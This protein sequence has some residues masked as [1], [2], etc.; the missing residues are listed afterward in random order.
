[1]SLLGRGPPP[2]HSPDSLPEALKPLNH[3]LNNW[4]N[5]LDSITRVRLLTFVRP[6]V[7]SCVGDGG[8]THEMVCRILVT[9]QDFRPGVAIATHD[10]GTAVPHR[11]T[12][13]SA[14]GDKPVKDG[15][16]RKMDSR[17]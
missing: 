9:S 2:A 1:M 6:S 12:Q 7:S 16:E 4:F 10:W 3:Q 5:E 17:D 8:D 15:M 13:T 11:F 14:G